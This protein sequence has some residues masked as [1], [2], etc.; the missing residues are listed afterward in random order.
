MGK[1]IYNQNEMFS[2]ALELS[3]T[4][5]FIVNK[6]GEIIYANNKAEKI[7]GISKKE[8]T[9]LTYNAPQWEITDFEGNPF[10]DEELPFSRIMKFGK[11]IENVQHAI[12]WPNGTIKF[13]SVNAIPLRDDNE[14]LIGMI[15]TAEDIS[16]LVKAKKKLYKSKNT[17]KNLF[18]NLIDEVHL[19][20]IIRDENNEI[21]TWK[22]IDAN[23][24]ALKAWGK[25]RKHVRGKL[26]NEIF[27]YDAV[28]QFM[29]IV[30][31][32][33]LTG[34]PHSWEAYFE[35]TNQYLSMSSIPFNDFFISTGRD[36]TEKKIAEKKLI[37]AKEKAEEANRLKTEFINNMSH[38][39][40]TPMNGII[41]FS[42]LLDHPNTTQEQRKYYSKIIQNSSHQLL[43]IID[44]ILEISALETK[45][46]KIQESEFCLNDLLMEL[47]S[48]FSL[49]K[50]DNN[51]PIYVVK[52]LDDKE[53]YIISDLSKLNKILSNLIENAIKFTHSGYVEFGYKI[54][55]DK[56]ILYVKDTGI[57][58][59]TK[60][61]NLIFERFSQEK[62]DREIAYGG[63]GLGLSISRENAKLLGGDITVES[64]KGK[65]A[66]FYVTIPHN[67]PNKKNQNSFKSDG[68]MENNDIKILVAE[69]EEINY[70]FIEALFKNLS[71]FKYT[72]IHARNGKEALDM[73]MNNKDIKL[74]LMDIRMPIMDGY[75]A[76]EQIKTVFPQLPVIAQTAYSSQKDK[77]LAFEHGCDDFMTKPLDKDI[78]YKLLE[79]YLKVS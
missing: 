70:L 59:A 45:Q 27:S 54:E 73:C 15:A 67:Y 77:D 29:P 36:I 53:S 42:E 20:K 39:I 3:P 22:L 2:K 1:A 9:Q 51:I 17:Y 76:T 58:I 12:K 71:K 18:E 8:I 56:L 69:D 62:K 34:K 28:K 33:F 19:W 32:I 16:S 41:G 64:E 13:L 24:P 14:N 38:E 66:T 48:I 25:K 75:E 35:P 74:V 68:K 79:K 5:V 37:E 49:K 6:D 78:L 30:K 65:G 63:L 7:L 26:A 40:R 21:K 61:Q 47:F 4:S 72:L 57:G 44:D 55:A 10:P 50:Q 52:A 46:E 23:P 11:P 60:N 31:K 43:R